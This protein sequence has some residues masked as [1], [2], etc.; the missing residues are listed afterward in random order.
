MVPNKQPPPLQK[1]IRVGVT[2]HRN[3]SPYDMEN[4]SRSIREV[5]RTIR[6]AMIS[7]PLTP[8]SKVDEPFVTSL[9]SPIA[10]GSD[11]LVAE[12][13]L[14]LE[15]KLFCPLPLPKDEYSSD[16]VDDPDS[17]GLFH[18]LIQQADSVLELDGTEG[19]PAAYETVGRFIIAHSDVLIAV[20][21]GQAARG[22]GGTAQIVSEALD[23]KK[24]VIIIPPQRP[25]DYH[26]ANVNSTSEE[27]Q[28]RAIERSV[29][30]LLV[31]WEPSNVHDINGNESSNVSTSQNNHLKNQLSDYEAFCSEKPF[32]DRLSWRLGIGSIWCAAWRE[33]IGVFK[34]KD[35][36][37]PHGTSQHADIFAFGRVNYEGHYQWADQLANYYAAMYRSTFL[38]NYFLGAMAV[39]M[40]LLTFTIKFAALPLVVIELAC[41]T[42]ILVAHKI[43]KTKRWHERAVNYRI[44]AEMLRQMT[45]L[46][47]VGITLPFANPPAHSRDKA[48]LRTTWMHWH[49]STIVRA[50][51]IPKAELSPQL[52]INYR[53]YIVNEWIAPQIDYH[54]RNA[55]QLGN[56][57]QYCEKWANFLFLATA[58]ACLLHLILHWIIHEHWISDWLI[59]LAAGLPAWAAAIHGIR[60]QGEFERLSERSKSMHL[61]LEELQNEINKTNMTGTLLIP[62]AALDFSRIAASEMLD[63]VNDWQVLYR[64]H[65]IPLP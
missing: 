19:R 32:V 53:D 46:S 2:G 51:G 22:I 10:A 4:L 27:A 62:K 18:K 54:K 7:S 3:L 50:A 45:F 11:Q 39:F 43:G 14:E 61:R 59:L 48:D 35:T 60:S 12:I 34:E 41:I 64:A 5:L 13:A 42:T 37:L 15:Y 40:A 24:I 21:D 8:N 44:L 38:L 63:E 55:K 26:I 57:L 9:L 16:F 33:F 52:L 17:Q 1:A 56:A 47:P 31:P 30:R 6:E 23:E 25:D 28:T 36:S 20:W 29:F 58:L 65:T 49:F